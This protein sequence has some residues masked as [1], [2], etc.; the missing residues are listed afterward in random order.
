MSDGLIPRRYAKAL[1]KLALENGDAKEIYEQ[2]KRL[3]FRYTAI[4]ELKRVVM[5]PYVPDEDKGRVLLQATGAAPGS[6]LDRFILM[7]IRNN[8]AEFLGKIGLAYVYLYRQEN[9]IAKVEITTATQLPEKQLQQIVGIVKRKL[10]DMTLEIS[11]EID[12]TLI[13]GFTVKIDDVLLDASVKNEL[14]QLRL[15]L[16]KK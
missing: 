4:D 9:N 1:Y 12:E 16:V 8:R 2:L 13:G 6:S 7:V 3:N 14:K 10:G 11:H 15:Q 5:N